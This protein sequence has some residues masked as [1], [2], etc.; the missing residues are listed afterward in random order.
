VVRDPKRNWVLSMAKNIVLE[1]NA[2]T[3]PD[4]RAY[5]RFRRNIG[6]IERSG[7]Y[8]HMQDE[9]LKLDKQIKRAMWE[10]LMVCLI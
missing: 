5:D 9:W 7:S 4:G 10:A 2:A 3:Q 1:Y 6:N 8:V